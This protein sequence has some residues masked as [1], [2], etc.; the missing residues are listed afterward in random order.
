MGH[1]ELLTPHDHKRAFGNQRGDEKMSRQPGTE[2]NT[3]AACWEGGLLQFQNL[4]VLWNLLDFYKA[5][6]YCTVSG[7]IQFSLTKAP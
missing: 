7:Q 6:L 3:Q 5:S 2:Q 1:K 4:A